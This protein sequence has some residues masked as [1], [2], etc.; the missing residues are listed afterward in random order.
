M[1]PLAGVPPW[2]MIQLSVLIYDLDGDGLNELIASLCFEDYMGFDHGK[3]YVFKYHWTNPNDPNYLT[4][5]TEGIAFPGDASPLR[6]ERSKLYD[7]TGR[8]VLERMSQPSEGIDRWS[9]P[10]PSGIYFLLTQD[11]KDRWIRRK[12]L[13]LNR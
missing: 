11:E 10:I 2:D 4:R 1:I 7:V 5:I 8:A 9:Y 13:Y 3:T 12:V 6:W